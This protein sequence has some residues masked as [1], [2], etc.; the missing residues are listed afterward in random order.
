VLDESRASIRVSEA[1]KRVY[2]R[3][4]MLVAA[5]NPRGRPIFAGPDAP[6]VY[7]LTQTRNATPA[8]FDF[9]DQSHSTRGE[10]LLNLLSDKDIRVVVIN[11][12]NEQSPPLTPETINRLRLLYPDGERVGRFEVRWAANG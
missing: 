6:E 3:V 1:D 4:R 9:L 5:H 2:D 10:K 8:L 11:E 12:I 7:F